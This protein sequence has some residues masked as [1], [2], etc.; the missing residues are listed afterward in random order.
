[1][2][3]R[4]IALMIIAGVLQAHQPLDTILEIN[5]EFRAL[6]NRDKAFVRMIVST[7]LRRLGQIDALIARAHDRKKQIDPPLLLNIL[8][9]GVA[10][11]I[12]MNVPDHAS[13][14][15][16]VELAKASGLEK[17][18]GFVNGV[19]RNI[20]KSHEDW[21]P[22]IDAVA[23]NV[24]EWMFDQWVEDYGIDDAESIGQACLTEAP[25]DISVKNNDIA[26]EWARKLE[27]R[28]MPHGTLRRLEGGIV[29]T[30]PGYEDGM[31]WVQDMA[32]ALPVA[33]FGDVKGMRVLDLCAAPGGKTTQLAARGATVLAVDRSARRLERMN[34]NMKRLRLNGRVECVTADAAVWSP[35]E[36]FDAILLDAPCTATGTIRRNPDIMYMKTLMDCEKLVTIQRRLLEHAVTMLNPGGVL[37]YCNCSLQKAEGEDQIDWLNS[38]GIPVVRKPIKKEEFPELSFIVTPQGDIRTR[39]DYLARDGGMDGFFITRLVRV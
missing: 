31:W 7:V 37:V 1:M 26:E 14:D 8:R 30:L 18:A 34:Q 25:L 21:L 17:A 11:I 12:F 4:H 19:L 5:R 29:E 10:Q 6:D 20:T 33:V 38:C 35:L 16:S 13:V 27:A 3:T 28:V 9:L 24:A 2:D 39:P 32:A 15:T 22:E 36:T 23:L